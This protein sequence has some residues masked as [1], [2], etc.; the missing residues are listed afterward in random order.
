MTTDP[1]SV[2]IFI[3]RR[4]EKRAYFENEHTYRIYCEQ[5]G[6]H[7]SHVGNRSQE[8]FERLLKESRKK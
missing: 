7:G 4:T 3:D 2:Y 8:E 1:C 6:E 5:E